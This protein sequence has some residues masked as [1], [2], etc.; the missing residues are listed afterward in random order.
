MLF[1]I[2]AVT[3]LE[4]LPLATASKSATEITAATE[5]SVAPNAEL[6]TPK[7]EETT[8]TTQGAVYFLIKKKNSS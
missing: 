4:T 8:T 7:L 1:F 2:A 5:A 6:I 3:T